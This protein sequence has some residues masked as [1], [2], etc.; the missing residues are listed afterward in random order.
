MNGWQCYF[1][2]LGTNLMMTDTR[3]ST[4]L[5]LALSRLRM[6][7]SK[8]QT[9]PTS[10]RRRELEKVNWNMFIIVQLDQYY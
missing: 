4:P 10:Q 2:M 8:G 9:T 7:D 6:M 5:H 1:M 3:G